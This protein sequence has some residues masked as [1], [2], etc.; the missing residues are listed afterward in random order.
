MHQK[1]DHPLTDQFRNKA[2]LLINVNLEN[3]EK[4]WE[5]LLNRLLVE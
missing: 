4:V 5:I 2:N 3:R 1:L